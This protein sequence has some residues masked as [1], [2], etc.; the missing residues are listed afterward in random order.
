MKPIEFAEKQL[1]NEQK[2]LQ[3]YTELFEMYADEKNLKQLKEQVEKV[4]QKQEQL[5]RVKNAPVP[6]IFKMIANENTNENTK[7]KQLS[8]AKE[9]LKVLQEKQAH[10]IDLIEQG[11]DDFNYWIVKKLQDKIKKVKE[12]IDMIV[13]APSP[14][15]VKEIDIMRLSKKH[16]QDDFMIEWREEAEKATAIIDEIIESEFC[17]R[18]KIRLIKLYLNGKISTHELD[19]FLTE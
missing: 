11:G 14:I 1:K 9:Q 17:S 2:R 6:M 8:D 15:Y 12:H 13:S 7:E 5:E 18:T 16:K 3:H 4:K 19:A 10:H